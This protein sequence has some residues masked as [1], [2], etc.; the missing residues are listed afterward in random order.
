MTET[1]ENATE[2]GFASQTAD[3]ALCHW[4]WARGGTAVVAR[5]DGNTL[6]THSTVAYPPGAPLLATTGNHELYEMKV[7]TCKK[8][9][10]GAFELSG[11]LVNATRPTRERLVSAVRARNER[12]GSP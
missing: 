11:K 3:T 12:D 8:L 1:T 10:S 9:P 4:T 6:T 5:T 7:R 2:Q